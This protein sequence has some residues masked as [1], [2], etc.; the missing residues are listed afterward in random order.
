MSSIPKQSSVKDIVITQSIA[1]ALFVIL[2]TVIT[3]MAPFTNLEFKKSGSA[4]TATIVRYVLIFIPWKT[5]QI[6]NVSGVRADITAAKHYQGTA[7]ERRKGQTGVR[8]ATGQI[9][10]LSDKPEVIVQ[11]A[12][13][14]AKEVVK[15][16]DEF[17]NKESTDPLKIA[18]YASWSLS[19]ILGGVATGFCAL[20]IFGA[21]I[22]VL[23][24]PFKKMRQGSKKSSTV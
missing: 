11:A 19:Y 8:V 5:E 24:Y 1:L 10:I 4:V 13:N 22:T 17:K 18:V 3:L 9:A 16:F 7:E 14:L 15:Q 12:P 21:T 23:L 2:P 6:G 20:Y